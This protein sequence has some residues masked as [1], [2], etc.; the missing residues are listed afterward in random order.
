[1]AKHDEALFSR[2]LDTDFAEGRLLTERAV[3]PHQKSYRKMYLAFRRRWRLLP[4]TTSEGQ[5]TTDIG[6]AWRNFHRYAARRAND[7][8][9]EP[10]PSADARALVFVVRVGS[11]PD[12]CGLM[13]WDWDP[14]SA[15][16]RLVLDEDC[17]DEDGDD[18]TLA[19]PLLENQVCRWIES[20]SNGVGD[21][22]LEICDAIK[23]S[24]RLTLHAV[25]VQ[26]YQAMTIM[27]DE[28]PEDVELGR[29]IRTICRGVRLPDLYGLPP[30]D[31]PFYRSDVPPFRSWLEEDENIEIVRF[32][33]GLRLGRLYENYHYEECDDTVFAEG[34]DGVCFDF[35]DLDATVTRRDEICSYFRA[36]MK[37]KCRGGG[38]AADWDADSPPEA[39]PAHPPS[40][41]PQPAW[42]AT[43][44]VLDR[45][46]SFASFEEQAGDLRLVCRKFKDSAM[47]QLRTKLLDKIKVIG[48]D[49]DESGWFRA[50][51]RLGWS[52][53]DDR[54]AATRDSVVDE[55]LSMA[56]CLCCSFGGID[57]SCTGTGI[58]PDIEEGI[59]LRRGG[60]VLDIDEARALLDEKGWIKITPNFPG[61]QGR[62]ASRRPRGGD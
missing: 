56:A 59:G 5:T 3:A 38:W 2:H 39:G 11:D 62:I 13:G 40:A 15:A 35:F 42:V 6:I 45:V 55:A 10:P 22:Y 4:P 34:S 25:D 50:D 52:D 28:P 27:E 23:A 32:V 9:D 31:S 44:K 51:V 7:D 48:F 29:V 43:D 41:P 58:C 57:E 60:T 17:D 1:M 53:D 46:L 19:F 37:E 54:F 61:G 47:L 24:F 49:R 33:G 36:L 18:N 16:D 30:R 12:S 20:W 14:R 8:D 26:R 21:H